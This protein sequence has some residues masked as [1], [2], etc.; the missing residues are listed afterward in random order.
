MNIYFNYKVHTNGYLQKDT[1]DYR[2][3]HH[4]HRNLDRSKVLPSDTQSLSGML[5]GKKV[6][7]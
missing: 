7:T 5:T 4:R 1:S 6:N 3:G 2:R